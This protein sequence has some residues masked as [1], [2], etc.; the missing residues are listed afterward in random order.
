MRTEFDNMN[1]HDTFMTNDNIPITSTE[2]EVV[3]Y[4][5][6]ENIKLDVRIEDETVWLSQMQ[7]AELFATTKQNISLHI[8]NI[9]REGELQ[10]KVV[11]KDSFTTTPHGAIN[12]K[13]QRKK[14]KLYNL[15][16]I[17]SVGYRVKSQ[18]GTQFR[19]WATGILKQYLLQGY[20]VNQQ[21]LAIQ[22]QIDTRFDEHA[23][24]MM[25][26]EDTQAKQQQQLDFFIRTSTP[27][28]EMVFFEGDFYTARAALEA[29]VKTATTRVI[30]IDGYVSSLTLSILDVRQ[31]GVEAIIYTVGVGKGMT[32]LMQEHD[33]LFPSTHIDIRKWRNESHDRWLIIDDTLYHCGHSLNAN[34]GHKISAITR[35]QMYPDIILSQM[36]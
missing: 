1:K 4:Q 8:G 12:G 30:I 2:A 28:A 33:R 9:F 20:A 26:I 35:M 16:V 10:Q 34:G 23:H 5:P 32:N 36:Q 29:L 27:P 14:L 31:P 24:R 3:L 15:D 17:I 22:R 7:M 18:R 25:Q 19:I 6:D 21:L 13:T 11:V